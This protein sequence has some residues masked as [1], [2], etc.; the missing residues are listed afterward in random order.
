MLASLRNWHQQPL[1]ATARAMDERF[2]QIRNIASF[3]HKHVLH[4][5][6]TGND[7]EPLD[8]ERLR[9]TIRTLP[10]YDIDI[11]LDEQTLKDWP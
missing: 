8:L 11:A 1:E 10:F 4:P 2:P 7:I 3:I 9:A 6:A 5:W